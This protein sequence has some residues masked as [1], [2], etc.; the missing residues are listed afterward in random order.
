MDHIKKFRMRRDERMKNRLD[1]EWKTIK[2]THVL[3]DDEGQVSGGPDSLK[4]LIKSS[5]GFK[6][7]TKK[8]T[9]KGTIIKGA[10]SWPKDANSERSMQAENKNR[11]QATGKY[12]TVSDFK[13]ALGDR[14]AAMS[15][16]VEAEEDWKKAKAY[17]ATMAGKTEASLK[18]DIEVAKKAGDADKLDKAQHDLERYKSGIEKYGKD[19]G[20]AAA[21]KKMNDAKAKHEGID[22]E[23]KS[24]EKAKGFGKK[25]E[26]KSPAVSTEEYT[27]QRMKEQLDRIGKKIGHMTTKEFE[28]DINKVVGD[29]KQS[30]RDKK[31]TLTADAKK[32]FSSAAKDILPKAPVGTALAFSDHGAEKGLKCVKTGDNSWTTSYTRDGKKYERETT[33][34]DVFHTLL[35]HTATDWKKTKSGV[36]ASEEA[37]GKKESTGKSDFFKKT[38]D[39]RSQAKSTQLDMDDARK[40]YWDAEQLEDIDEDVPNPKMY[41]RMVKAQKQFNDA[42]SKIPDGTEFEMKAVR[43]R[44]GISEDGL[45]LYTFKKQGDKYVGKMTNKEW[46]WRN[47]EF[48]WSPQ[49]FFAEFCNSPMYDLRMKEP[50]EAETMEEGF[51]KEGYKKNA[52]GR[53][54]AV[55]S[56]SR[57]S[58]KSFDEESVGSTT[59]DRPVFSARSVASLMTG[60]VTN[61]LHGDWGRYMKRVPTGSSFTVKTGNRWHDEKETYTKTDTGWRFEREVDGRGM[62][63]GNADL[64]RIWNS[65]RDGRITEDVIPG[66]R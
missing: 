23:I 1:D 8:T 53:W 20:V 32:Q 26:D 18:R 15:E 21:E 31:G 50:K 13:K 16:Y 41:G 17:R 29:L 65:M 43:H 4:S 7:G 51:E 52:A 42:L 66:K 48:S 38:S 55:P 62:D 63:K 56:K 10:P 44:S 61:D 37:G 45:D 6:P 49:K 47:K 46:D 5:G 19:F 35:G 40:A 22:K 57:A 33:D 3:I 9:K 34:E 25:E 24:F 11:N 60:N 12:K 28:D 2:G 64:S 30:M 14:D 54:E 27:K 39:G 58:S 59:I 36:T